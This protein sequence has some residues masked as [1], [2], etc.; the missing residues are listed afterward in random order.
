MCGT[1][2]STRTGRCARR[3]ISMIAAATAREIDALQ[4]VGDD[5]DLDRRQPGLEPGDQRR[6]RSPALTSLSIRSRCA[7][8]A[9]CA[10]SRPAACASCSASASVTMPG[11]ADASD[12][13]GRLS[14]LPALG[15]VADHADELRAAAERDDV[16]GDVGRRRRAGALR[17]S[18]CTTGTGAS[19][20]MRSTWPITKWSSI[21]S[22]TTRTERPP[23]RGS[24]SCRRL[25]TGAHHRPAARRTRRAAGRR[26]GGGRRDA[27]GG[28]GQR[29]EQQEQHQELGVAEVVFEHPGRQH[30]DHPGQRRG[31]QRRQ[32]RRARL[33][34]RSRGAARR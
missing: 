7:P 27:V 21:R 17:R 30:R 19:G 26:R 9:G 8:P 32:R 22:P 3:A 12:A 16:V 29:H 20:E 28:V 31:R 10:S 34:Q 18:N 24:S 11:D 15:V 6:L 4:V 5:H 2:G 13:R 23:S 1:F 33:A 14:R 25:D